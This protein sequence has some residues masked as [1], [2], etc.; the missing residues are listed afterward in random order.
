MGHEFLPVSHISENGPKIRLK[1]NLIFYLSS[2]L[3]LE[4]F[5]HRQNSLTEWIRGKKKTLFIACKWFL[6]KTHTETSEF[7][8]K[9]THREKALS[10]KTPA[11][12]KSTNMSVWAV[13]R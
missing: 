2:K 9:D 3:S 6:Q 13:V 5:A 12:G 10:N 4:Y 1:T 8:L 11:L 7:F